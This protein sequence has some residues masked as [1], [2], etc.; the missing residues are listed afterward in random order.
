MGGSQAKEATA[1]N[2]AM[3]TVQSNNFARN[4]SQLQQL[5]QQYQAGGLSFADAV[6]QANGMQ[7]SD[8]YAAQ[9]AD[10][11]KRIDETSA[12]VQREQMG[13]IGGPVGFGSGQDSIAGNSAVQSLKDELAALPTFDAGQTNMGTVLSDMIATDPITGSRFAADEVRSNPLTSGLFRQGGIQDQAQARFGLLGQNIQ[14][15][16]EALMGRGE[17]YGLQDSDLKA[18]GQAAANTARNFGGMEQ[19]LSQSLANRGLGTADSGAALGQF[20]G[21]QGNKMEQLANAQLGIAQSRINTAKDLATTR[22]S[23]DLQAQ[24]QNN[25]LIQGLGTLGQQALSNQ[26]GRQMAGS[27]NA[28][29]QNAGAAGLAMEARSQQ[30][31][32]YDNQWAQQ[33]ASSFNPLS[34]ISNLAGTAAGAAAGGFGTSVGKSLGANILSTD[35]PNVIPKKKPAAYTPDTD[36]GQG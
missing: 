22:M 16:R 1:A 24:G 12:K 27:E 19:S 15:S 18:Y 4:S 30:Q 20:A 32:I 35:D 26:F 25:G 14:D 21:M 9:R 7:A 36:R 8:P 23:A 17:A 3:G 33:Q 5:M 11:Q 13:Q 28:Y 31:G 6:K 34:A 29:N 2:P 10:L